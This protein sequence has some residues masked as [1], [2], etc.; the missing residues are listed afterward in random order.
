LC[1]HQSTVLRSPGDYDRLPWQ[2]R[3]LNNGNGGRL[4]LSRVVSSRGG[5]VIL[6]TDRTTPPGCS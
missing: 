6:R 5:W 3:R 2:R 1:F 4:G